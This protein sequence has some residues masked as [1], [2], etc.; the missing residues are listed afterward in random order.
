MPI[1][2]LPDTSARFRATVHRMTGISLPES[3]VPMIEQRLRR[4]VIELQQETTE[5]YLRNLMAGKFADSEMQMVID[6]ITTNTTSFFREKDHFDFLESSILPQLVA[7][8]ARPRPRLKLWS[9]A[10][11]EGAE[12]FTLAMVL[13]E[14]QRKGA[15]FDW[16]VLGTD[17]SHN[18]VAKANAGIYA[19]DQVDQIEPDLRQRYIMS[20]VDP[21]KDR[22]VRIVP[23]LRRRVRFQPMNLMDETYPIDRDIDV[24]FLRNVLIYF[25]VH[26]RN[27][28]IRRLHG[29]LRSG[30]Y[31]IVGHSEGMSV[32]AHELTSIRPTI[33]RKAS[34]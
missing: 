24:I 16:A 1:Q 12:A 11:S 19:A 6:L 27:Q 20:S 2:L 4:R 18:M 28:V 29:H 23:E 13:A 32:K 3:K 26:D 17:I 10:S 21:S 14:A 8:H 9:A 34:T 25:N 31:L 33:F 5:D 30:G 15:S 7:L 22:Q